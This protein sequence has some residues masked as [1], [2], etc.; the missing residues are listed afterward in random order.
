MSAFSLS[1]STYSPLHS[2]EVCSLNIDKWV[3]LV[4]LLQW[5]FYLGSSVR[6]TMLQSVYLGPDFI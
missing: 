4:F 6:K 3:I 2:T 5:K 1:M